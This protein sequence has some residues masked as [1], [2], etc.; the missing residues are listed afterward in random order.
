MWAMASSDGVGIYCT[1]KKWLKG[2]N[3]LK[4]ILEEL[5]HHSHLNYKALEQKRGFFIYLM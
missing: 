4:E 3:M 2:K 1:E 5:N